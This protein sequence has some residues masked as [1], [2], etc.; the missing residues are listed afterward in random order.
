MH[1]QVVGT[2]SGIK[3]LHEGAPKESATPPSSSR[4]TLTSSSPFAANRITKYDGIYT[5]DQPQPLVYGTAGMVVINLLATDTVHAVHLDGNVAIQDSTAGTVFINFRIQGSLNISAP[6]GSRGIGA[7]RGSSSGGDAGGRDGDGD[8]SL[9]TAA[10][11]AAA[12]GGSGD[13][14]SVA[15]ATMVG[16]TDHD[17][18]VFDDTSVVVTDF[19][20]EQ[21]KT[22]HVTLSGSS[23]STSTTAN[24]NINTIDGVATLD[25]RDGVAAAKAPGRVTISAVKS[26]CYSGKELAITNYHGTVFYG[27]SFFMSESGPA[28]TVTQTGSAEVNITFLGNAFWGDNSSALAWHLDS[29]AV[30]RNSAIGNIVADYSN[31]AG[32]ENMSYPEIRKATAATNNTIAHAFAD[33]AKLGLL[34]LSLNHP[35]V[36][37]AA[38]DVDVE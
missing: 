31:S 27:N 18:N 37:A 7:R 29:G 24:S 10:L 9:A 26:N 16:L 13:L 1:F 4:L 6:S 3:I 8:A 33:F 36:V 23:T 12:A 32:T 35:S 17:M 25:H 28:S 22:A 21:I 14:P 2:G 19:Y 34:D 20:N 11:P 38:A 30:G 5:A 15:V